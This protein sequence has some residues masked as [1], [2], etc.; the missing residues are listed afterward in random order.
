[1][2]EAITI[3]QSSVFPFPS[4][5][6]QKEH[7][8]KRSF[9]GPY[10]TKQSGKHCTVCGCFVYLAGK[11]ELLTESNK[12]WLWTHQPWK[13]SFGE[14]TSAYSCQAIPH[15]APLS[16]CAPHPTLSGE[17]RL[18]VSTK[19]TQLLDVRAEFGAS[20][21]LLSPQ[22]SCPMREEIKQREEK[23]PGPLWC[24]STTRNLNLNSLPGR[25]ALRSLLLPEAL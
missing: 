4:G 25:E 6:Y 24:Q 11:K 16:P 21:S 13:L 23:T 9:R 5:P 2:S 8:R 14:G 12:P 19:V 1:M 15:H 18:G 7:S 22:P 17:T 10:H 3:G 20:S